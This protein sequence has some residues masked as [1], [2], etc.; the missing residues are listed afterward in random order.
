MPSAT[1]ASSVCRSDPGRDVDGSYLDP[2]TR[3]NPNGDWCAGDFG[4]CARAF[5]S[6]A[7]VVLLRVAELQA[8]AQETAQIVGPA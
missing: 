7:A 6:R 4:Q 1:R 3:I 5:A 2:D 8:E